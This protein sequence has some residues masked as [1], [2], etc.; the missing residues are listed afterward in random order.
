MS[1]EFLTDLA[2]RKTDID[3]WQVHLPLF[4]SQ[5]RELFDVLSEKEKIRA[6]KFVLPHLAKR[7]TIT[8]G[9]LRL[10]IS[11]YTHLEPSELVFH[12]RT[13]GKPYLLNNPW[14]LEFNLSHSQ[15]KALIGISFK[16]EIGV[17]IE[18]VQPN[19]LSE[20]LQNHVF[21]ENEQTL[22]R[23]SPN[24]VEAFYC[25]WTHKEA[26]LKLLG[27]GFYLEPNSFDVPLELMTKTNMLRYENGDLFLRSFLLDSVY[28]VAIA[29]NK[30]FF[31]VKE[32]TFTV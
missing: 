32:L 22:F 10:L 8:H 19:R 23:K 9:I 7:Y 28:C 24:Q 2:K 1:E 5:Q 14:E 12:E 11:R 18:H 30:P 13:K 21:T 15:E 29:S 26:I 25:G 17:D 3:I 31:S 4:Y 20:G 16:D 27:T 6:R